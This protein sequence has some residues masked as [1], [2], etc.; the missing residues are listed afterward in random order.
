[1][2]INHDVKCTCGNKLDFSVYDDVNLIEIEPCLYCLE[3]RYEDGYE[4]G[5]EE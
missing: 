4:E 2:A 5:K 1:M 3:E